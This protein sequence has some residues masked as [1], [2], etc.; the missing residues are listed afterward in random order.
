[1]KKYNFINTK[2]KYLLAEFLF[3]CHLALFMVAIYFY[4][5]G[6]K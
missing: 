6:V 1:M 4:F 2:E 3:Y 5:H